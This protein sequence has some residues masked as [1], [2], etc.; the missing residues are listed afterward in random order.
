MA[1]GVLRRM[2]KERGMDIRVDSSG[3]G[4]WHIGEAPDRRAQRCMKD[5][6]DDISDLR[7][8]QFIA[9]DFD[10]FDRIFVM[11]QSNYENVVKLAKDD[12]QKDKVELFL[13]LAF[14][15]ED[16]EVPDPYFGG[17]EGF[18]NVYRMLS[19]SAEA[20]LDQIDGQVR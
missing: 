12:Q 7:A 16:R 20:L 1:E 13:N 18:E 5:H 2:A 8:R 17:D 3:T 10:R 6:G 9:K 11:D 14:P 4:N 19:K 15:G